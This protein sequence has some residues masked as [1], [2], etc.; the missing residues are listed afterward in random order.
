VAFLGVIC[1]TRL[2][3]SE[4]SFQGKTL[5]YWLDQYRFN[6][7]SGEEKEA[8]ALREDAQRAVHQI[9]TNAIPHLL[10]MLRERDSA[11][12][13]KLFG[14]VQKQRLIRIHYK[15]AWVLNGEAALGFEMLS[16]DAKDA[17]PALVDIFEE[18]RSSYSREAVLGALAGIGPAASNAIPFLLRGI[19]DANAS[20]RV[21]I[22][23]ALCHIRPPITTVLP[24]LIDCLADSNKAVRAFA[25]NCLGEYGPEARQ[26]IPRLVQL[27]EDPEK[28]VRSSAAQALKKIDAKAAE[29]NAG[30][31]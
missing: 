17:V 23:N 22:V 28:S 6:L 14:L 31:K 9:G 29:S 30:I 8:R 10:I 7:T 2:R 12:K 3:P 25:A 11:F 19:T 15:P 20:V 27:L 5:S 21:R 16:S 18:H 1:W 4:P 26:A 24:A 13:A